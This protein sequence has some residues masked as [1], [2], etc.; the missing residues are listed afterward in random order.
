MNFKPFSGRLAGL[1]S[2]KFAIYLLIGIGFITALGTFIPQ[3]QDPMFYIT[4]Y[5]QPL[6]QFL[7]VLSLH[8]LY[9]AWWFLGLIGIL[10]GLVL[11]CS[12]KRLRKASSI[13]SWGSLLFHVAIV[14]ILIGAVWSLAY[15]HSATMEISPGETLSISQHGFTGGM[16]T[17][18][19]F[20]IDYYPDYQ[21][22]QYTS[23]LSLLGYEG[24]DYEQQIYVNSPLRAGN[25]KIYQSSWG[26]VLKFREISSAVPQS[27]Q[28][29]EHDAWSLDDQES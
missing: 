19:S 7:V 9:S 11:I 1:I 10:C 20:T 22:R 2:M 25:L 8:N 24:R 4:Y 6:G 3:G 23:D 18:N 28:I 15:A 12:Y 21:P 17:L 27:I 13:K 5:G 14:V 26:W 29:K 16:L